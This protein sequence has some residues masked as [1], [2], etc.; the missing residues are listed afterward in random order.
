MALAVFSVITQNSKEES[1]GLGVGGASVVLVIKHW[2]FPTGPTL[3]LI[4]F[5]A[6]AAL[7]L[8]LKCCRTAGL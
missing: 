6:S 8:R 1:S 3:M 4:I 7:A 5:S 2:A